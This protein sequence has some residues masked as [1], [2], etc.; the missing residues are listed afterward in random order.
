MKRLKAELAKAQAERITSDA[1]HFAD[2]PDRAEHKALPAEG[3]RRS[4]AAFTQAAQD[5]SAH[6]VITFAD[7]K[8]A[9][10]VS[11]S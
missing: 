9:R 1:T 7:G 10:A 11:S 8:T 5:D 2:K 4:S 6:G 3:A